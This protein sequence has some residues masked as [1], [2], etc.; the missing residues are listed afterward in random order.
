M[1]YKDYYHVLGVNRNVTEDQI[2]HAYR[3]LARKYHPD[4]SKEPNAEEEF[5]KVQEAY[6]VLKDP[7]KRA[8][9]DELG[10]NWKQGQEFRP[11]PG[12][13]RQKTR[14]Y[15]SKDFDGFDTSGFSDFFSNLFGRAGHVHTRRGHVDQEE[16]GNFQQRGSNQHAA[17]RITLEE[18]FRGTSKMLQ[19]QVPEIDAHGQV[20]YQL[21]SLKVNIP[22]GVIQGQELRLAE[23]AGPGIGGAPAGDLYLEID[24]APHPLFSLKDRDVYLTLPI[25]PWE[26]ALGAEIKI[27]TLGGKVELKLVPGSHAGQKLRLKGRGMP[28]KPIA[29]DQYAIVQIDTPPAK[30]N[31][32]RQFYEKMSQV[33]PFNPRQGWSA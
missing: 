26:A 1:E 6:E 21:R 12:W 11:P 23:Q 3:K 10:S 27:P 7:K 5:K 29:G 2:K 25:T 31:E 4:V 18:A 15:T 9:Y 24:I 33:M 30:T 13:E 28:G 20:H 14:F 32:D 19:V 16:M 17:I 22:A 8:A